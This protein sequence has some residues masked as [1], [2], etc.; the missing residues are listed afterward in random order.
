M[1]TPLRYL[2]MTQTGGKA[3]IKPAEPARMNSLF[4]SVQV[5]HLQRALRHAEAQMADMCQLLASYARQSA[6]LRDQAD[7]LVARLFDFSDSEDAEI[8]VGLRR[9][10][11]D[12]ALVQDYRHAQVQRLETQ[13]VAPLKAY[14]GIIANTKASMKMFSADL[15]GELKELQKLENIRLKNLTARQTNGSLI[16]KS[17]LTQGG[18]VNT[19]TSELSSNKRSSSLR[20]VRVVV[21]EDIL[22]PSD[23]VLQNPIAVLDPPSSQPHYLRHKE[24]EPSGKGETQDNQH[25][26]IAAGGRRNPQSVVARP[27]FLCSAEVNSR[28]ASSNAQHSMMKMEESITAFHHQKRKDFKTIFMDFITVEMIF[29]AKALEVYSHAFQHLLATKT[30]MHN[31]EDPLRQERNVNEA[32]ETFRPV[33]E[34]KR[35]SGKAKQPGSHHLG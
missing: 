14:S 23:F 21:Q 5:K 31:Q 7:T 24:M 22:T 2:V 1:T 16:Q 28:K 20:P 11:Q 18:D 34:E 9:L 10:A 8:Q 26:F 6:K 15:H 27:S 25:L 13:V 19:I 12:L 3:N 32:R 33:E 35:R 17:G 29:H 4:A 30:G